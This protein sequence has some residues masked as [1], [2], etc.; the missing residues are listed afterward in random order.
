MPPTNKILSIKRIVS[1]ASDP[2]SWAH[3]EIIYNEVSDTF[4]YGK[5]PST[6]QITK[7]GGTGF[8]LTTYSSQTVTSNVV[9]SGA[10]QDFTSAS[11][12]ADTQPITAIGNYVA[13]LDH[14]REVLSFLDGGNFDAVAGTRKYWYTTTTDNNLNKWYNLSSWYTDSSH[15]SPAG[16]LPNANTDVIVLGNIGPYID[17]DR[18]D[19]VNPNSI[20]TGSTSVSAYSNLHN[21]ITTN[22]TGT[23]YFYGNAEYDT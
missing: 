5:D 22:I 17:L 4:Y 10:Q 1:D 9:M 18:Q 3:G 6:S 2:V 14:V 8:F 12:S 15:L 21:T 7:I 16:S 13:N 20:N 11:L 23:I 19:W